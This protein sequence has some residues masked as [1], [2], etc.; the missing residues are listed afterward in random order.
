MSDPDIPPPLRE[1]VRARTGGFPLQYWFAAALLLGGAAIFGG[2][3]FGRGWITIGV[4]IGVMLIYIGIGRSYL[5]YGIS[6]TQYADSIYYLGF[7]FTLVSITAAITD[8]GPDADVSQV[9]DRF[10]VKLITTLIGLG[11]RTYLVNFSPSSEDVSA[12]VEEALE[13]AA[14]TLRDRL[15]RVT[16]DLDALASSLAL[17]L[18]S[19]SERTEAEL[20]GALAQ[21]SAQFRDSL[22]AMRGETQASLEGLRAATKAASEVGDGAAARLDELSE[23][24]GRA[25]GAIGSATDGLVER[26]RSL[27]LPDDL[28]VSELAP[29]V[30]RLGAAL[31]EPARHF[32]E[33]GAAV[34]TSTR[35]LS[36]A[37]RRLG[38][39][40]EDSSRLEEGLSRL[41][42]RLDQTPS[43]DGLASAAANV[44]QALDRLAASAEDSTRRLR[45]TNARAEELAGVMERHLAEARERAVQLAADH[46]AVARL[47]AELRRSAAMPASPRGGLFTRL[48]GRRAG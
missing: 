29:A 13:Q 17:T 31:R 25:S 16:L 22:V 24:M 20:S 47:L 43:L 39:L 26:L 7:L 27:R 14:R 32:D 5:D 30:E 28:L 2:E 36:E 6:R 46:A 44:G 35:E 15:D 37:G 12:N 9:V 19:A 42:A 11:M 23:R 3:N 38:G 18:K 40:A 41:A 4:P 48:F 45:D 34:G 8:V 33:F 10:G 21:T 1:G